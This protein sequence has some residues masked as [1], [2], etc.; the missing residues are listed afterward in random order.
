[1]TQWA[2]YSAGERI[3]LLRGA[4][5]TQEQLAEAAGLSVATIRKAE[6]GGKGNSTSP[7]LAPKRASGIPLPPNS[8][9]CARWPHDGCVT[10]LCLG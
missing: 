4:S 10:R 6:Q 8:P 1:M 2:E 9:Q 3:K 7:S 5:L